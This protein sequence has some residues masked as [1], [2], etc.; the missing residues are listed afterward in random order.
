MVVG[1]GVGVTRTVTYTICGVGVGTGA[2]GVLVHPAII[3][4]RTH[5]SA[6]D[7]S[8]IFFISFTQ[9]QM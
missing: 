5:T 7:I 6:R 9:N 2:G 4:T 1:A 8:T 3:T